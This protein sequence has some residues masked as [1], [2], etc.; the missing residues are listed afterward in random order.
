MRLRSRPSLVV[1][2]IVVARDSAQPSQANNVFQL[3]T[4]DSL[5]YGKRSLWN[6]ASRFYLPKSGQYLIRLAAL[7]DFPDV[8]SM[9]VG[10]QLRRNS[11]GSA[12]G[13][14]QAALDTASQSVNILTGGNQFN[15]TF[16]I[17][18][19]WVAGEYLEVFVG[20][21]S[22]AART[23]VWTTCTYEI[24]RDVITDQ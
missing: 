17:V 12:T 22:T 23:P 10:F 21:S 3:I 2:S 11:A 16:E 6:G 24:D 7:M 20:Q 9:T 19:D 4:F 14:S 1:P 8:A 18:N 15:S 5:Y 13:G